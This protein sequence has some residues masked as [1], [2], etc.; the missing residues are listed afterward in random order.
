MIRVEYLTSMGYTQPL[1]VV[2]DGRF[3]Q[4]LRL[5][6]IGE[7]S[8]IGHCTRERRLS[9]SQCSMVF[10]VGYCNKMHSFGWY[11]FIVIIGWRD[12]IENMVR[13]S[14]SSPCW[15]NQML[16]NAILERDSQIRVSNSQSSFS[17]INKISTPIRDLNLLFI[18]LKTQLT[19]I[20]SSY[21]AGPT[22]NA[23]PKLICTT[24]G[25][26]F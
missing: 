14:G 16:W 20:D 22:K 12:H 9:W 4:P 3:P 5:C 26:P 6:T 1:I 2:R 15:C 8:T 11:K 18:A 23:T 21:I 25:L 17:F 10:V 7:I 13:K 19:L 24:S